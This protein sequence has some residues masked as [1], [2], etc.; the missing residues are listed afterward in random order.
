MDYDFA[1]VQII[2]KGHPQEPPP[3]IHLAYAPALGLKPG[4]EITFKVRSFGTTAGEEAIDF[5]DG[6]PSA[7]AK[8]DGG[9]DALAKDGYA[10]LKHAFAKPGQYIVTARRANERGQEGVTRVLVAVE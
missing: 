6:T 3:G 5:G 9:A 8:S 1:I 2:D 10:V 4:Q 7:K